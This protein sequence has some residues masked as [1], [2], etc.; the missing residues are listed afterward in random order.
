MHG[1]KCQ[2]RTGK[3]QEVVLRLLLLYITIYDPDSLYVTNNEQWVN[4]CWMWSC[5]H[6]D[7]MMFL[8]ARTKSEQWREPFH[9][10]TFIHLINFA[11]KTNTVWFSRNRVSWREPSQTLP[12]MMHYRSWELNTLLLD[13]YLQLWKDLMLHSAQSLFF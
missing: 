1:R 3:L 6:S 9:L 5:S 12:S 2:S 10:I 4:R 13:Y 7:I 11:E 8:T